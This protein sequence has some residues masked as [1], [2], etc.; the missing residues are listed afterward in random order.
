M[1]ELLSDDVRRDPYPLYQS[2]RRASPVLRDPLTG[3]WM[4][5][6]FDS[7]KRALHDT[8]AF[9][10]AASPGGPTARWLIFSDPP[11]HTQLRALVT[12]AFTPRA[13]AALEPRIRDIADEL[14]RPAREAGEMDLVAGFSAPLPLRVIAEML[15][16]DPADWALY[17]R[18]SDGILTLILTLSGGPQADAAVERFR[19][20]HAEMAGYVARLIDER[21]TA[22]RDDLLTRMVQAEVE[23]ER[24]QDDDVL[25]FFQLLLLAGH[26]TTTNLISNA[27]LCFADHPDQLARVR[28][29]PELLPAAIE[30]VLRYRSPVQAAFRVTKEEVVMHGQRIAPG[31]RVVAWIGSA[32]RDPAHV[33]DPD[34]FDV[35]R[36]PNP[37]L[38]FGHGIHFC[39][40][41]PLARLEARVALSAL[42]DPSLGVELASD[43]P[44][45][46]RAAFHVHGPSRLPVRFVPAGRAMAGR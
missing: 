38:A 6:D 11:R 25:G 7:V 18:W 42:L 17:R 30:E 46:P 22:P 2:V 29:A 27:V 45:E 36:D 33:P 31:Q 24:M 3:L 20:V 23:G 19:A 16:A 21:R 12:R 13:V 8:A 1:M 10:S 4:L 14:L 37:H 39:V 44:W 32:N 41:A 40:G 5:F 15:G 34:G 35:T 26:E 9:S 43:A 28:A